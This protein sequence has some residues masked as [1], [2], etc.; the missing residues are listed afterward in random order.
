[1]AFNYEYPQRLNLDTYDVFREQPQNDTSYIFIDKLP[2][3]LTYGKH[4]G[5]LSWRAPVNSQYQV[6]NGSTIL[7]ELKD[8]RGNIIKTDLSNT[9]PVNGSAVFYIWVEKNPLILVGD[10]Y[11][12]TDGPCTLT[13][14]YELD[15]VPP[16]WQ[17]K[18]NGRSTFQF[19]L[20]K[21]LPNTSPILFY[22]SSLI[23]SSLLISESV[24][25]DNTDPNYKRSILHISTSNLQTEGGKI[26]FVEVAY[27]E[28]RENPS[29]FK[30]LTTY[31]ISASGEFFEK[32]AS[33]AIGLNPVSHIHKIA[34]P[35]D[36]RRNGDVTFKLRF[37][38]PNKEVARNLSNNSEVV[39]TST[40][41]ITGSPLLL[42]TSDNLVHDS[43]G[44][45]FGNTLADGIKVKFDKGSKNE[46]SR[47]IFQQFKGGVFDKEISRIDGTKQ[48]Y[49][50]ADV[51]TNKID[52]SSGS[53]IMGGFNNK[54]TGSEFAAIV[55]STGSNIISGSLST[56][57]GGKG[58]T[59]QALNDTSSLF[60]HPNT[61]IGANNSEI[62][63]SGTK[64]NSFTSLISNAVVGGSDNK[65][66]IGSSN[67][68]VGGLGCEIVSS[69]GTSVYNA[70]VGSQVAK[71]KGGSDLSVIIGSILSEIGD[72]TTSV[73]S[74]VL[75]VHLMEP[76]FYMTIQ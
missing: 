43:G 65:I 35:K 25:L 47:L 18:Y 41:P 1:M 13:V 36:I 48:E 50:Y 53:A 22:S 31:G 44:L 17:G 19:E 38:N 62:T 28:D 30:L 67:T 59:I 29:E 66:H 76:K 45:F 37:L 39:V 12:L 8:Q 11:E 74:G 52:T 9:L 33:E 14:V 60:F 64:I 16:K 72:D 5:T 73:T 26:D 7:F 21:N 2:N 68:I 58:N 32:T 51:T 75:I 70:I 34:I 46:D 56:I 15:G 54:I 55:N 49:V 20:Q 27:N 71:I 4:F 24:E 10:K 57:V 69:S 3:I 23:S 6:K 40:L 63:Q 42:E 61:I